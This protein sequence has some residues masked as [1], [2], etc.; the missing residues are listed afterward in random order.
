MKDYM[1]YQA[2]ISKSLQCRTSSSPLTENLTAE[3]D[4]DGAREGPPKCRYEDLTS[5]PS[6]STNGCYFFDNRSS[7]E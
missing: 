6:G 5:I 7:I 3:R 4:D 1:S 2:G